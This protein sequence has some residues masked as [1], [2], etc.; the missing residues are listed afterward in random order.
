MDGPIAVPLSIGQN[1]SGGILGFLEPARLGQYEE[2]MLDEG[3]DELV[4]IL[5]L[6]D[7][8]GEVEDMFK[9]ICPLVG[10]RYAACHTYAPNLCRKVLHSVSPAR[11][12]QASLLAATA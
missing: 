1:L 10:H 12:G 6:V 2:I 9:N 5:R 11:A 8:E 3:Y 4:D 7:E